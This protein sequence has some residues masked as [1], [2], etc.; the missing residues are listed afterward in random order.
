[1]LSIYFKLLIQAPDNQNQ[2]TF[3]DNPSTP[4][5]VAPRCT[6]YSHFTP[7]KRYVM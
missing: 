2:V 1:M 7:V 6:P 3:M 5:N 4:L